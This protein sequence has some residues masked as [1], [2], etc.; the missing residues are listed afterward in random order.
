MSQSTLKHRAHLPDGEIIDIPPPT[1]TKAFVAKQ[2]SYETRDA[3]PLDSFGPTRSLPIGTIVHARSGDKGSDANVG[4]YVRRPEEWDWLRSL[5]TV[6]KMK[7]MLGDDYKGERVD[8][9]ELA[10]LHAVHFLL[11][12]HLDRGKLR[13]CVWG[14]NL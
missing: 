10:N 11:K 1:V 9:F 3:V 5:L 8:R 14:P 13:V 12:Q 7:A 6:E 2:E 4:F